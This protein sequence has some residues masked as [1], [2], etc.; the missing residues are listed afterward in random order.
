MPQYQETMVRL[1][2][3][4][5]YQ[6]K[7]PEFYGAVERYQYHLWYAASILASKAFGVMPAFPNKFRG[8]EKIKDSGI[9]VSSDTDALMVAMCIEIQNATADMN[10]CT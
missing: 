10:V 1:L 3:Q 8:I 9:N 6:R 2:E 5:G 7:A 4:S